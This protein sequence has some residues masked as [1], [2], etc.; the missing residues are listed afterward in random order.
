MDAAAPKQQSEPPRPGRR[1]SRVWLTP[2]PLAA[3]VGLCFGAA[4]AIR[5]IRAQA[6]LHYG[7]NT[8][9]ART[10]AHAVDVWAAVS[11]LVFYSVLVVWLVRRRLPR[12]GRC[13]LDGAATVGLGVFLAWPW[14][15]GNLLRN[16]WEALSDWP[17]MRAWLRSLAADLPALIV[18]LAVC[19]L[20]VV[21]AIRKKVWRQLKWAEAARRLVRLGQRRSV[22]VPALGIVLLGNL[23]AGGLTVRARAR[24]RDRPN[25]IFIAVCSLRPDHLGCYG[26]ARA[27]SPNI[28]R[29]AEQSVGF[30][31]AVSQASW[32]RPS[33]CSFLTGRHIQ[34]LGTYIVQL[35]DRVVTLAEVLKN[36][37]YVTIGL[38]SNY[39]AGSSVKLNQ[40]FGHFEESPAEL[41]SS[42]VR[43]S[44]RALDLIGRNRKR[45]FFLF[46]L[47]ADPHSPYA[48]HEGFTFPADKEHDAQVAQDPESGESAAALI[49]NY[50]SEIAFT[51]HH[52][53]R[54]IDRL[55]QLGL[56]DN[57]LIVFLGDHGEAFGEHRTFGHATTLYQELIHVPLLVKLPH[58]KEQVIVEGA[59]PLVRLFPTVLQLIGRNPAPL[60][61]DGAPADLASMRRA[62]DQ[63]VFSATRYPA[64]VDLRSAQNG[65]YKL[66]LDL[67]TAA[68]EL[69]DLRKD[70]GEAHNVA[71]ENRPTAKAMAEMLGALERKAAKELRGMGTQPSVE[72][73]FDPKHLQRLRDL[74]YAE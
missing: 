70:P 64:G 2:I 1:A 21:A 34:R 51:D 26:Y 18:A 50:D 14:G 48:S 17:I 38:T 68:E 44:A 22:F 12:R 63:Y 62:P 6:Y 58:Q 29:L 15:V 49:R 41:D 27:T 69:Y 55:K 5:V 61:L 24:L 4:G 23:V 72:D 19:V 32:T 13:V 3:I 65:H 8:T 53:G 25:I 36:E 71:A 42:S 57:S 40:G 10:V 35:D 33:V 73:V 16:L 59:F 56:Y 52:I 46:M 45:K 54:V 67:T 39:N 66:I 60:D 47:F 7:L 20:L 30:S 31:E 28:D 43:L 37:G 9:A 74:G 11:L